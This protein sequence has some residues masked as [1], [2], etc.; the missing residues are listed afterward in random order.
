MSGALSSEALRERDAGVWERAQRVFDRPFV[1]EAGAGT[2]KTTLLVA[3]CLAWTLG[4]GWER[5]AERLPG[6]ARRPRGGGSARACR[7]AHLHRGRGGRDGAAHGR[8]ARDGRWR[9]LARRD[10]RGSAAG[11]AGAA[12][13]P[14]DGA[15]RRARPSARA[16]DPRLL[17]PS[18]RAARARSRA[19]PGFRGRCGRAR[20]PRGRARGR[21]GRG[22]GG[23]RGS[24]RS[25]PARPRA[26]GLRSAR[27]RSG[28]RGAAR[29]GARRERARGRSVRAG[30]DSRLARRDRHGA[31][32]ISRKPRAARLAAP[33]KDRR[34]RTQRSTRIATTGG[35]SRPALRMGRRSRRLRRRRCASVWT[36]KPVE[37]LG[38]WSREEFGAS[39]RK[40]LGDA[41]ASA[42]R[43]AAA[44]RSAI[45][46][47][48]AASAEAPRARAP[49]ADAPARDRPR[50]PARA[51]RDRLHGAPARRP[52]SPA[53]SPGGAHARARRAR[54]ALRRRVPGHGPRSVRDPALARA[55]RARGR[56]AGSLPGRR[57]QAIDLRLARGRSRGLR[58]L[59]A[60]GARPRPRARAPQR[61]PPLDA[62]RSWRRS[63][64]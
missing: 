31:R 47:R 13:R 44:L 38:D 34:A 58:G 56:A 41:C 63:R 37:R 46:Q 18:A 9:P 40:A 35:W 3:R 62:R 21:R 24:G 45:E 22:G 49:R 39:E 32:V 20:E 36:E 54:S 23:L 28:A 27:A 16:H 5:A 29:L 25:G 53:R 43:A 19:A 2:G 59:R 52:R 55:R 15:A 4:P 50:A 14:R 57:S 11:I 6:A 17:P 26:R 30:G 42:A 1:V 60:R 12:Q 51:R 7:R 64:A 8:G 10:R 61:E 33:R 48:D